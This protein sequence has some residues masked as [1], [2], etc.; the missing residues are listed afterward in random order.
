MKTF[1]S[2]SIGKLGK[3]EYSIDKKMRNLSKA[4]Q[5]MQT[6]YIQH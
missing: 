4:K 5:G 6:I 2:Y 1:K 3:L